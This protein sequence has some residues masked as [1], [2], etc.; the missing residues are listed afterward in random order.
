MQIEF[1][2]EVDP[3]ISGMNWLLSTRARSYR[4]RMPLPPIKKLRLIPYHITIAW[5]CH[6]SFLNHWGLSDILPSQYFYNIIGFP[7]SV[8]SLFI[9][10]IDISL[11]SDID[12]KSI[13]S[14]P[15]FRAGP[16]SLFSLRLHNVNRS[17]VSLLFFHNLLFFVAIPHGSD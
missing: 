4:P 10:M 12:I 7:Q 9:S 11:L 17:R 6:V 5:L 2:N 8:L 1:D 15:I 14:S 16:L 3:R 13:L